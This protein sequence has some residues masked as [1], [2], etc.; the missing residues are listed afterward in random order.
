MCVYLNTHLYVMSDVVAVRGL[1]R[2]RRQSTVHL[3][4]AEYISSE[5]EL[6]PSHG[7]LLTPLS[8]PVSPIASLSPTDSE[9]SAYSRKLDFLTFAAG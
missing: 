4:D 7:F 5:L 9:V 8:S 2:R 3:T 1:R 6:S